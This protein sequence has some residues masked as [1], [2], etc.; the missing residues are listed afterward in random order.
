AAGGKKDGPRGSLVDPR[1]LR[2]TLASQ[3]IDKHLAQDARVLDALSDEQF[4]QAVI[5][6]RAATNRAFKAVVNAAAI[7]Q[8]RAAYRARVNHGGT[9]ADL[10]ALAASG[11]RAGL[12][13]GDPPWP[14]DAAW[15][16]QGRQLN[17]SIMSLD[18]IKAM[19]VAS[20]AAENCALAL[21]GV[22]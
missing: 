5:D 17:Y 10:A 6:A 18:Q 1:D 3:G 21:W 7:E 13:S 19:P 8:E 20:L 14:C 2:P 11:Y 12:I 16:V 22:W 9:V 4:E 15:S